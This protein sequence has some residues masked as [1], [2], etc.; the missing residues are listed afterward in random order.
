MITEE[1]KQAVISKLAGSAMG[2]TSLCDECGV[3]MEDLEE[4]MTDAGYE[5][6]SECEWWCECGELLDDDS[7]VVACESCRRAEDKK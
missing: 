4:I 6:C 1:V 7:N 5:R 3:S 2:E